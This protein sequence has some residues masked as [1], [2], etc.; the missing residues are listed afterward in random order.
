MFKITNYL[1]LNETVKK[2]KSKMTRI[3]N[4]PHKNQPIPLHSL[5]YLSP[6]DT[7][8]APPPTLCLFPLPPTAILF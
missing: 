2:S 6:P 5:L 4:Y 7:T 1:V 3:V 8:A